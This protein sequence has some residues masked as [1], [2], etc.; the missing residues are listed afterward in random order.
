MRYGNAY[1]VTRS[2]LLP[3][4]V[5]ICPIVV[6]VYSVVVLVCQLVV[7]VCPFF[8]LLVVLVC[9][10]VVSVC[11][12]VVLVRPFVCPLVVFVVLSV[13]L[14]ITDPERPIKDQKK[15]AET[16]IPSLLLNENFR[17]SLET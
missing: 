15:W 3:L 9:P 8:C 10:L 6:L 16:R 13:G 5:L 12:L 1:L 11:P 14:F 4:V 17:I 7:I 2:T